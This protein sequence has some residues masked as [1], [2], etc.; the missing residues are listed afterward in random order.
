LD[1]RRPDLS[2]LASVSIDLDGVRHY[3]AIHGLPPVLG[4]D[5]FLRDGLT[6]FLELCDAV[7]LRATL[8]VVTADL[9]DTELAELLRQAHVAGHE[10]AS[11]SHV[12]D[13]G[14]SR[15]ASTSLNADLGDSVAALEALTGVAPRG[16]RAPGYNLSEPLLDAVEL[17]GLSYDASLLPSPAY[18][19]ARSLL[20]GLKAIGRKPSSSLVGKL[21]AFRPQRG[22][23]RMRHKSRRNTRVYRNLVELPMTAPFGVPWIGTTVVGSERMGG[24][25]THAALKAKKPIDLELHPIDCT[26]E[27]CVDAD[28]LAARRDLQVP[29]GVRMGRLKT[30]LLRMVHEREVVTL[31]QVAE[32]VHQ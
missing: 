13:Y 18:W 28:L 9:A 2:R 1:V 19:G 29:L 12:H 21:G 11:H 7:G 24:R 26:D 25:L 8:F 30:T 16:F 31:A 27:G 22:P 20:I 10:L 4:E 15:W 5:P 14:M 23:F 32:R 6:R 3:R 17:A